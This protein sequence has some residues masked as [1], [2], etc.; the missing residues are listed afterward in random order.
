MVVFGLSHPLGMPGWASTILGVAGAASSSSRP[1][2]PGGSLARDG[3]G[4][5][6]TQQG[7]RTS[8]K[9]LRH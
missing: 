4:T 2:A 1:R 6:S 7:A 9:S 5:F 3:V 8:E